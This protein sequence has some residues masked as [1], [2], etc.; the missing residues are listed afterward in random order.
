[1]YPI[2]HFS[3]KY[4]SRGQNIAEISLVFS[5]QLP[6]LT[7]FGRCDI[8]DNHIQYENLDNT[9]ML[10]RNLENVFHALKSPHPKFHVI[11]IT[12][13][14]VRGLTIGKVLLK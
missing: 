5:Q 13:I 11:I 9:V 14:E 1:M 4:L 3:L 2:G 10:A 6:L 12:S 8:L 7:L